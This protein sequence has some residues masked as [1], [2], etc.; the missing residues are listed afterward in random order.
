MITSRRATSDTC[1]W[2]RCARP[3]RPARSISTAIRRCV[4]PSTN[5]RSGPPGGT[6][7]LFALRISYWDLKRPFAITS[8]SADKRMLRK[9]PM[10][11]ASVPMFSARCSPM[12][13]CSMFPMFGASVPMFGAPM[14]GAPMFGASVLKEVLKEVQA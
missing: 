8:K 13:R 2:R 12:F 1:R 10:F 6:N 3:V 4:C 5:D 14:F 7:A 11:G 9:R